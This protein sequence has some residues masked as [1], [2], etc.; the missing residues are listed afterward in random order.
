[1]QEVIYD[2]LSDKSTFQRS[3]SEFVAYC[4]TDGGACFGVFAPD[5][6][7]VAYRLSYFPRDREFN[8]GAGRVPPSEYAYVA[9]MDTTA[10]LPSWRRHGLA[11][12]LNAKVLKALRGTEVRH[13]F[14]TASPFNP[15]SVRALLNTG[16]RTIDMIE[17]FGGKLRLLFYRPFPD[18]WEDL[19]EGG[20]EW[21]VPLSDVSALKKLMSVGAI[22]MKVVDRSDE[23]ILVLRPQSTSCNTP[24]LE[25]LEA[26]Q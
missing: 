17:K 12:Q 21:H 9:H 1:M 3:T 16:L 18:E 19:A 15:N 11:N 2:G 7:L 4:L 20:P 5:G 6:S 10:V 26:H 22:G 13:L 23:H 14:A 24:A 25:H 8:L